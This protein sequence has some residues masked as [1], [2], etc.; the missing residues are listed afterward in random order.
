MKGHHT[1]PTRPKPGL[2]AA[3]I[4]LSAEDLARRDRIAREIGRRTG[5]I[6]SGVDAVR[7]GLRELAAQLDGPGPVTP[8]PE[9]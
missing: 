4:E 1:M 5:R 2:K 9:D 3:F 8:I 7:W 6:P